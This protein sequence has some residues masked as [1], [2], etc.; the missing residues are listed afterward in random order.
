MAPRYSKDEREQA[1]SRTRQLLL[2]AAAEEFA[3]YGYARANINRISQAAGFAKGTIYN[4]F[5]SKRALICSLIDAIAEM[6]LRFIVSEVQQEE[7]PGGRLQH[8]FEAGFAFV[9]QHLAQAQVMVNVVYGP[10]AELKM[11]SFQ[12]YQ[13]MFEFV[14]EHIVAAG[15]GRGIFRQVDP[16]ATAALL[17]TIYLGAASQVDERGSPWLDPELVAEFA[18]SALQA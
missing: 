9:P 10:D 1:L 17:M 2:D 13:P 4:Y 12:A 7:D 5:P 6:H 8:F 11:H 18:L 15:V 3:R 16:D 14:S